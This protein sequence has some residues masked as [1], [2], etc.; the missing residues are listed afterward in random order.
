MV[1]SCEIDG[2]IV[3]N[4]T[5]DFHKLVLKV[6]HIMTLYKNQSDISKRPV[7]IVVGLSILS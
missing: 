4:G 3:R 1:V 6:K 7:V 5:G 2:K